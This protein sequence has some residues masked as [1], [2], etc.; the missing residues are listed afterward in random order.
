MAGRI[1]LPTR[2]EKR[3]RMGLSHRRGR[4]WLLIPLIA[5][6]LYTLY[7]FPHVAGYA[8]RYPCEDS[9]AAQSVA[10]SVKPRH[11]KDARMKSSCP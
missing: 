11:K 3:P 10:A 4:P 5:L 9:D 8:S 6:V 2:D 7:S 1:T